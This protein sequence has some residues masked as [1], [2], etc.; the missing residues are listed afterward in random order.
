MILIEGTIPNDKIIY[1][2]EEKLYILTVIDYL[3]DSLFD[4]RNINSVNFL[5][6]FTKFL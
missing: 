2:F 4:F 5:N 3:I 1:F 6:L